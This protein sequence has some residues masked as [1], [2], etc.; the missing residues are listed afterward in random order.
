MKTGLQAVTELKEAL[1]QAGFGRTSTLNGAELKGWTKAFGSTGF[2]IRQQDDG[3]LQWHI[4]LS[5]KPH[6][7]YRKYKHHS[8]GETYSYH[9][10]LNTDRIVPALK[11]VLEGMGIP[12]TSIR[13]TGHQLMWDDDVDFS[14]VGA[15]PD[16]L[17]PAPALPE[18]RG[19]PRWGRL[20]G[21]A[22]ANAA[23]R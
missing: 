16:W 15:H 2:S 7:Q 3:T 1:A 19:D 14:I 8:N 11:A 4:V 9:E 6:F 5:G 21:I 18:Y 20:F 22:L 10:P 17:E 23:R 12:V 13:C